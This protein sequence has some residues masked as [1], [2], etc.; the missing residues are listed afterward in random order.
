MMMTHHAG[1]CVCVFFF[2]PH[3]I[4]FAVIDIQGAAWFLCNHIAFN[5]NNSLVFFITMV[6]EYRTDAEADLN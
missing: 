2:L 6:R 3:I 5:K 1:L 4:S